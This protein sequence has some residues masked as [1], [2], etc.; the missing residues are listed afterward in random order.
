MAT[1]LEM[2]QH[3]DYRDSLKNNV[4]E[5]AKEW[6]HAKRAAEQGFPINWTDF[7]LD[8]L[9]IATRELVDD[10]EFYEAFV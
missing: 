5:R 1:K 3:Q 9:E 10:D 4:V 2:E 6:F 7:N 8:A